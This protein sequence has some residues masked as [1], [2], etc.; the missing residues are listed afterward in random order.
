MIK[1]VYW[2]AVEEIYGTEFQ[3][4]KQEWQGELRRIWAAV[5][6][7]HDASPEEFA[8]LAFA[9]EMTPNDVILMMTALLIY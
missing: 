7:L 2:P 8:K 6:A 9:A 1:D 4:Y 3:D 5:K